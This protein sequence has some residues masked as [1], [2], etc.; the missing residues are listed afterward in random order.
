ML[1]SPPI[2]VPSALGYVPCVPH[3]EMQEQHA[4]MQKQHELMQTELNHRDDQHHAL[5]QELK[6]AGT[7]ESDMQ[8]ELNHKDEQLNALQL[9]GACEME[10]KDAL[11]DQQR[12]K[13]HAL[14]QELHA[15]KQAAA[16]S[17]E[18]QQEELHGLNKQLHAL[19]VTSHK[20]AANA[21]VRAKKLRE[22]DDVN[23]GLHLDLAE[24]RA[25]FQSMSIEFDTFRRNSHVLQ[26][27][28]FRALDAVKRAQE[29]VRRNGFVSPAT[30][31]QVKDQ[32]RPLLK[33]IPGL[34]DHCHSG[35]RGLMLVLCSP[36]RKE[37]QKPDVQ[38]MDPLD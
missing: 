21:K 31:S 12:K 14:E 36:R 23:E 5:K 25:A 20:E 6:Q 17:K 37:G 2:F 26:E 9:T 18:E 8:A 28:L 24:L 4:L 27:G 32:V 11:M 22:A 16:A 10:R 35:K 1:L 3:H 13:L 7:R 34:R 38:D 33:D 15:L 30:E 19:K 29:E